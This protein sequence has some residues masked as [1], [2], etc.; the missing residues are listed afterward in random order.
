[1][2]SAPEGFSSEFDSELSATIRL[3]SRVYSK[4]A[5]LRTCHWFSDIAY[6]HLPDSPD[7]KFVV[8]VRLKTISPTLSNPNPAKIGDVIG[9]FCNSLLEFEL[10]RQVEVET[11]PVR[12]LILAK[13]FSESGVLEDEPPGVISDPVGIDKPDSFVHISDKKTL[14]D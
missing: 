2:K 14:V 1:V 8:H 4:E 7:A 11:A 10:R 13:A 3:D 5:I 6:L 9:E 12:E